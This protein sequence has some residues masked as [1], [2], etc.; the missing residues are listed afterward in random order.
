MPN[1]VN[2]I[3][4]PGYYQIWSLGER[5]R[6]S[7]IRIPRGITV[8]VPR[9][10]DQNLTQGMKIESISFSPVNQK[11]RGKVIFYNEEGKPV[12]QEEID[13]PN[14]VILNRAEHLQKVIE[15]VPKDKDNKKLTVIERRLDTKGLSEDQSKY[16][17]NITPAIAKKIQKEI[18]DL[19]WIQKVEITKDKQVRITYTTPNDPNFCKELPFPQAS[20]ID[21]FGRILLDNRSQG[22][23]S[24]EDIYQAKF[25][26]RETERFSPTIDV[27]HG[28]LRLIVHKVKR[29]DID[30]PNNLQLPNGASTFKIFPAVQD[31]VA[32]VR[33]SKN[34]TVEVPIAFSEPMEKIKPY[35]DY[36]LSQVEEGQIQSAIGPQTRLGEQN[37][38]SFQYPRDPYFY[39][40][41]IFA[42][43]RS[44]EKWGENFAINR[45]KAVRAFRGIQSG[46]THVM[47]LKLLFNELADIMETNNEFYRKLSNF[48]EEIWG[49]GV[50]EDTQMEV[51]YW[52]KGIKM[53]VIKETIA[54]MNTEKEWGLYN[55]QNTQRYIYSEVLFNLANLLATVDIVEGRFLGTKPLMMK[56]AEISE[57]LAGRTW[58]KVGWAKLVE[59]SAVPVYLASLGHILFYPVDLYYFVGSWIFRTIAS[60]INYTRHLLSLGYGF[61]TGFWRNPALELTMLWGYVKAANQQH[62]KRNQYGT[63]VPT[64]SGA[65]ETVPTANRRLIW[66]YTAATSLGL[67]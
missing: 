7:D 29:Y 36:T 67:G 30:K 66:G 25:Y 6:I 54:I 56:W 32:T 60:S 18:P 43:A 24:L 41:T 19:R 14:Y 61:V 31:A 33:T 47:P 1:G 23:T 38:I 52:L 57:I 9:G 55:K 3:K 20:F 5:I 17:Y 8:F 46:R 16:V 49:P 22:M 45:A 21:N 63:F 53:W 62:I 34:E 35:I 15:I 39:G 10:W 26:C 42:L 44:I 40:L 58:Y 11:I 28:N 50:S 2:N 65:G 37:N 51:A 4:K 27:Y 13:L 59:F 48:A 12:D 64:R